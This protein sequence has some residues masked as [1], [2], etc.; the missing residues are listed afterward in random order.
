MYQEAVRIISGIV[1]VY[2]L[3]LTLY[4][5]AMCVF[6]VAPYIQSGG[7]HKEA[8]VSKYAG[9]VYIVGGT[10]LFAVVKLFF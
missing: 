10:V 5:G 2:F 7:Y 4:A 1:S 3:L 8:A 6:F 9:W